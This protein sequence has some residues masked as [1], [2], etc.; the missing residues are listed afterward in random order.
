ML[1][2]EEDRQREVKRAQSSEELPS[3]QKQGQITGKQDTRWRKNDQSYFC[4]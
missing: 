1:E 4:F 3:E 2:E